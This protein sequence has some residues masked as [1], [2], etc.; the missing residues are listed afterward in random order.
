MSVFADEEIEYLKSQLLGRLAT[1]G[2]DGQ[3]HVVPV[4]FRYNAELDT[5]DIGGHDFAPGEKDPD[6]ERNPPGGFLVGDPA[7]GNPWG[8]GGGG[9]SAGGAGGG[10]GGGGA[11]A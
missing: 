9:G 3:P 8:G 6:V 5:I 11:G 10:G 4:G 2:P 1:S 7:P